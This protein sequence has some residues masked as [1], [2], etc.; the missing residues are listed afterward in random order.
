MT[1]LFAYPGDGCN[2]IYQPSFTS[3]KVRT[4][5]GPLPNSS[6]NCREGLSSQPLL[7]FNTSFI[8]LYKARDRTS[9]PGGWTPY[10]YLLPLTL[11]ALV[12]DPTGGSPCCSQNLGEPELLDHPPLTTT[13]RALHTLS[14]Y[15]L[16]FH[17]PSVLGMDSEHRSL[18]DHFFPSIKS[19]GPAGLMATRAQV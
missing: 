1:S 5:V 2:I 14:R 6:Y 15:L 9:R 4:S 17:A 10:S 7:I 16:P 13:T 12:S 11:R 19:P 18:P 8:A 3:L